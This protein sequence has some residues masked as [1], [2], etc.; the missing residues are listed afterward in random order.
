MATFAFIHGAGDVGWYWHLVE[1]ELRA[2]GHDTVAPD[3]P[4]E[5]DDAGLERY[6]EVVVEA[7]GERRDVLV[8]AQSFGGYVAPLVAARV[9]ARLIVLVAG[10]IPRPGETAEAM[11]TN[12]GWQP[13]GGQDTSERATFYHDVPD[14]LATEALA[15]GRRQSDTPGMEPWPLD[16]WPAIPVRF[17]LGRDDRFFPAPWLRSVVRERLGIR[18]TSWTAATARPS[19]GRASWPRCSMATSGSA[20]RAGA[21]SA[22]ARSASQNRSPSTSTSIARSTSNAAVVADDRAGRADLGEGVRGRASDRAPRSRTA[23]APDRHRDVVIVSRSLLYS[24]RPSSS[25]VDPPS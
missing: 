11:F 12:T 3:L 16:A 21:G 18:P 14:D 20:R 7:I 1:A 25:A 10:M 22:P 17:V 13:A 23:C 24:S 5:D 8:V 6:A 4:C 9:D 19:A 2:R 15:R